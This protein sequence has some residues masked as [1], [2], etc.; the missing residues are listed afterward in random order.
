MGMWDNN[1][2]LGQHLDIVGWYPPNGVPMQ[3]IDVIQSRHLLAHEPVN[4]LCRPGEYAPGC[5]LWDKSR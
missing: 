3:A 2:P 1:N 5:Y 4:H